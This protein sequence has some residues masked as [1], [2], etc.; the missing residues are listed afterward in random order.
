MSDSKRC[1]N[2]AM[3]H[4]IEIVKGFSQ[5]SYC[6][7]RSHNYYGSLVSGDSRKD[8]SDKPRQTRLPV[9]ANNNSEGSCGLFEPNHEAIKIWREDEGKDRK[10]R[11]EEVG[12]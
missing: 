5:S 2:C 10:H 1:G 3:F 11:M 8:T 4:L 7:M 9:T 6:S 12:I